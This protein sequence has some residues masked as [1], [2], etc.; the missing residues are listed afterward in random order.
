MEVSVEVGDTKARAL[1]DG[2]KCL[3]LF[4]LAGKQRALFN[5]GDWVEAEY[6]TNRGIRLIQTGNIGIGTYLEKGIKKYISEAS[7]QLL[8][9]KKLIVGDILICRLAEPAGRACL[10]NE[11]EDEIVITSVD[12]T[13]FRPVEN[14]INRMYL[15][16]YF[17]T[18][19]WFS[20][21]LDQVGGTT[22]KRISRSALG[23]LKVM[24]PPKSEQDS[25]AEALT[26]ADFLIESLEKLIEKKRQIKQGTMQKLLVGKKRLPGFTGEWNV[27]RLADSCQLI[28]KG[29]TPTSLGKDFTESGINFIKVESLNKIGQIIEEMVGY[30]DEKTHELLKRSQLKENDLLVSIAGALGRTGIVNKAILPANTNQALAIVRFKEKSE[31]FNEYV[32]YFIGY[33]LI[34]KHIAGISAQGAQANLS[35]EQVGNFPIYA[36]EIDEQKAIVKILKDMDYELSELELKLTKTH[37]IKQGMMHELLTGRIRLG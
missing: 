20:S 2:W 3:T 35:L 23:S 12:V 30:I 15:V 27:K 22:H 18:D 34:S 7:F 31:L 36:P 32:Y 16:H 6:I 14:F 29:T 25:I 37:Q 5:D 21:V 24:L 4:E 1:S 17:S 8:K 28:T 19:K 26:D 9:C 33:D 10:F 13:I 11:I